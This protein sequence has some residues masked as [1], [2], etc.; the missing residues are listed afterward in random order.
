MFVVG[1]FRKYSEFFGDVVEDDAHNFLV[2]IV[3]I[4]KSEY[5][6]DM[7][8]FVST[9]KIARDVD[10]RRKKSAQMIVFRRFIRAFIY[11]FCP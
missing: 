10:I 3:N 5:H 4:Q 7:E 8:I 11:L 6:L 1:W 2:L 9:N